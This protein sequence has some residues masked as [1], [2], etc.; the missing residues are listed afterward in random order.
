[1]PPARGM[2]SEVP[3]FGR[4]ALLWDPQA[5][6]WL[7]HDEQLGVRLHL[8][9]SGVAWRLVFDDM[10]FGSVT[11][12]ERD[13]RCR[14]I[15]PVALLRIDRMPDSLH[16]LEQSGATTPLPEYKQEHS[17]LDV[18]LS[19]RGSPTATSSIV[20]VLKRPWGGAFCHWSLSALFSG[21]QQI[22]KST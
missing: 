6:R 20:Y 3:H 22:A 2:G 19:C 10:G 17:P 5:Q 16:V 15:L 13:I 8:P 1:M 21:W 7:L 9:E 18:P 11:D 12:G 4:L 14:D